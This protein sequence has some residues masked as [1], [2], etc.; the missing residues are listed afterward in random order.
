MAEKWHIDYCNLAAHQL[1]WGACHSFDH[2]KRNEVLEEHLLLRAD[3]L[4]GIAS[5]DARFRPT[6]EVEEHGTKI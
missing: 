6:A 5:G 3:F 1:H 2:V 4:G